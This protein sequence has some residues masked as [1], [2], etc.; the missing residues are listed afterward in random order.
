MA[1]C[2]IDGVVVTSAPVETHITLEKVAIKI[3][4]L[5]SPYLT[6]HLGSKR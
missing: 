3:G 1:D 5:S 2:S 4:I 6:L